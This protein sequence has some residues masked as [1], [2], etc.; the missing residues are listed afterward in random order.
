MT[1]AIIIV[2]LAFFL[3][4]VGIAF[5]VVPAAIGQAERILADLPPVVAEAAVMPIVNGTL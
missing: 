3:T 1:L 2:Y 4:V 5:I